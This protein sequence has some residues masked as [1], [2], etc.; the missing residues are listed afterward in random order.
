MLPMAA[1]QANPVIPSIYHS[2]F[3]VVRPRLYK[4][5]NLCSIYQYFLRLVVILAAIG[6]TNKCCRI[7]KHVLVRIRSSEPTGNQNIPVEILRTK[8]TVALRKIRSQVCQGTNRAKTYIK[9]VVPKNRLQYS[10]Y[11]DRYC[12]E[13]G[14]TAGRLQLVYYFNCES[15]PF[16]SALLLLYILMTSVDYTIYLFV[17][18]FFF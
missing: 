8:N 7:F 15:F 12:Q 17:V 18:A 14:I 9:D 2:C 4:A 3:V 16:L 6:S 10:Y 1:L 5:R 13:T 11:C